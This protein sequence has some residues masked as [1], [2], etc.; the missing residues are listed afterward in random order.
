M[1]CPICGS[2]GVVVDQGVFG[3]IAHCGGCYEG[4]AEASEWRRLQA[5][6]DE[7]EDA[8]E[9]WLERAKEYAAYDEVVTLPLPYRVTTPLRAELERQLE[10]ERVLSRGWRKVR[11]GEALVYRPC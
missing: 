4:D 3:F 5:R 9:L 6:A 1:T 11:E 2:A 8:L 10:Q 7:P